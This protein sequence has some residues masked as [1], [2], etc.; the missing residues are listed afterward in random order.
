MRFMGKAAVAVVTMGLAAGSVI[1]A[2]TANAAGLHGA[3][4]FSID[5][6]SYGTSNNALSGAMAESDA[7][8]SCATDGA[9][10]CRVFTSWTNGCGALVYS[11]EAVGT[12][13]GPDSSAALFAAYATL[14]RYYPQALL[15]DTGSADRSGAKVS[16]VLCTANAR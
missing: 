5:D 4:A 9:T 2:G 7:L 8:A 3:I 10:D 16:E 6:W 14:S 11:D 12:G 15:A 13:S 1:A